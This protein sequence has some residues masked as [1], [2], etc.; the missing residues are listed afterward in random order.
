LEEKFVE[1]CAQGS[2]VGSK[3]AK[4]KRKVKKRMR[5]TFVMSFLFLFW[6]EPREE[7]RLNQRS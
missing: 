3:Q 2:V 1:Q 4:R 5:S 7:E 6:W